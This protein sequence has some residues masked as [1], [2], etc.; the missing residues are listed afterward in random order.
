MSY[1]VKQP[2]GLLCRFST[3]VDNVTN[4]NMT[5]QEY[6]DMYIEKAK[7]NAEIE[8]RNVLK[9]H[10]QPFE[11]IKKDFRPD[12]KRDIGNFQKL[13]KEMGDS[14]LTEQEIARIKKEYL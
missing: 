5:E 14:G 11:N 10:I 6:I 4:Y 1:I 8:A 7:I 3:I 9:H 12:C 2:N 13:L